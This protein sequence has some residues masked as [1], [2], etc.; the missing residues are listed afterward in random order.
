MV[1]YEMCQL[2][3]DT[4]KLSALKSKGMFNRK[5][6]TQRAKVLASVAREK[7]AGHYC[8]KLIF[9]HLI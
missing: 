2:M 4:I 9:K 1:F 6:Q 7:T 5:Y 3:R 8:F